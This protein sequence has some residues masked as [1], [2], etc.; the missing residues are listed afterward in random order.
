VLVKLRTILLALP[1]LFVV[2]FSPGT[3]PVAPSSVR[4]DE[5]EITYQFPED[6]D[7]IAEPPFVLQ[8]CWRNPVNVKDLDQGGDFAFRLERP[9]GIGLGMRIV[10]QPDGYGVAIYPGEGP[11]DPPEGNW[12]WNYRVVDAESG[13]ALEGEVVFTVRAD[14]GREV[15][16]STPPACL[17]E[18]ATQ[19]ATTRTPGGG[20]TITPTPIVIDEEGD[21]DGPDVALLAALTIGAAGAAAAVALIGYLVRRRIGFWLHRPPEPTGEEPP[22]EEHH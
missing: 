18:G 10:F 9:D 19:Q 6:S 20:A 7:V 12:T 4:A 5:P 17:A 8:M 13:D 2:F 22:P 16:L 21:D 11:E 1:G 3:G 15:I 14:E